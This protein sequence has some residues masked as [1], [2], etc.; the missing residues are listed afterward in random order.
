VKRRIARKV[1]LNHCHHAVCRYRI[2]TIYRAM[3]TMN[4]IASGTFAAMMN[5]YEAAYRYQWG[6]PDRK[7][8]RP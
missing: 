3:V 6:E 2:P 8:G 4:K 1:M 5:A 7:D